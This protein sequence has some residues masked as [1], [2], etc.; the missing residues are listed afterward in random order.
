MNLAKIMQKTKEESS[1]DI[2][3]EKTKFLNSNMSN[4]NFNSE[5]QKCNETCV[6]T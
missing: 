2:K 1:W 6:S 4:S 3:E 5:T